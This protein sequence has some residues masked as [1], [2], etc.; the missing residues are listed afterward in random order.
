LPEPGPA[1]DSEATVREDTG[2]QLFK[3][4]RAIG[5][6]MEAEAG[7]AFLLVGMPRPGRRSRAPENYARLEGGSDGS[8]LLRGDVGSSDGR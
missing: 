6:R 5:S 3:Y 4:P 2:T 1:L 7:V 8:S